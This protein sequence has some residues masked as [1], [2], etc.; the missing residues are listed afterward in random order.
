MWHD[1]LYG[2]SNILTDMVLG[3]ESI[4]REIFSPSRTIFR[5]NVAS[6]AFEAVVNLLTPTAPRCPDMGCALKW[7]KAEY[8]RDYPCHG[9][10]F[11]PSFES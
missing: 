8:S 5:P 7:N 1:L 10:C 4:Y 3:K 9:S 2:V 11:T 6:N